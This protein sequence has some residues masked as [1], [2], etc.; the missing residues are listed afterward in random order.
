VGK[1]PE[2][3]RAAMLYGYGDLRVE[4]VPTPA[5]QS[6]GEVLVEVELCGI[7]GTEAHYFKSGAS[8]VE[9][10]YHLPKGTVMGHKIVGRVARAGAAVRHVTVGDRVAIEPFWGCG[11]CAQCRTG[12]YQ[13]CTGP[14][15]RVTHLPWTGGFAEY[16]RV[17][18]SQAFRLPG[19]VGWEQGTTADELA[20]AVH[21]A[22]VSGMS[23]RDRVAVIGGGQIGMALTALATRTARAAYLVA[24]YPVQVEVGRRLGATAVFGPQQP[25]EDVMAATAGVGVDLAFEAVGGTGP[26]LVQAQAM[27][28]IRGR[29]VVMGHFMEP[30]GVDAMQLL[31][32]ECGIIGAHAYSIWRGEREFQLALDLMAKGL[33]LSPVV[34]HRFTLDCI[35]DGFRA[36]AGPERGSAIK[37]LIAP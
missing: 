15:T 20:C 23:P 19:N 22:H 26:T 25:V 7:G 9:R 8:A 14:R 5:L 30:V 35:A 12:E 32:A 1:I 2:Q 34:T 13:N 27:L 36:M 21:A 11:E 3:M 16:T 28:A 10:H 4:E 37:V 29:V 6:D 33:D 24:K 17:P 18:G 31:R